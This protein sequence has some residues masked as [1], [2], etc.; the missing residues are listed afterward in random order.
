MKRCSVSIISD[1][2]NK[3]KHLKQK[4]LAGVKE[5]VLKR[6]LTS[7]LDHKQHL[8]AVCPNES[9]GVQ[10]AQILKRLKIKRID[11]NKMLNF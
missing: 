2:P 4:H 7:S 1:E 8:K 11:I 6:C 9:V 10:P 3:A 5:K